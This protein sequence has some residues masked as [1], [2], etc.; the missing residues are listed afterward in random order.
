MK[1]VKAKFDHFYLD[2]HS[3]VDVLAFFSV[4]HYTN[5]F[6]GNKQPR[7]FDIRTVFADDQDRRVI[8]IWK[9]SDPRPTNE[10]VIAA[11]EQE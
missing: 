5:S 10:Q 2:G 1:K 4:P 3:W 8:V 9:A 11:I 7:T 6:R